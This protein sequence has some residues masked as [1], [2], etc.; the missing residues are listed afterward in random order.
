MKPTDLAWLAGLLEGEGSF[1]K[2]PPS[3]PK[4][5]IV[6][7]AMTDRDVID[8]AAHLMGV[9][10]ISLTPKNPRHKLVW[11]AQAKGTRARDLM[12]AIKPF[13]GERRSGQIDNALA[14]A[15]YRRGDGPKLTAQQASVIRMRFASGERAADLA[16]EFGVSKRLVYCIKEGKRAS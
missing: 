15:T 2:P 1:L 9:G 8:R 6:R 7:V 13:M 12:L 16:A 3:A 4:L 10:V 11:I 14:S 5:A